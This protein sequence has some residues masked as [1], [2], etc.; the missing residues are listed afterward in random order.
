MKYHALVG[1]L[2]KFA[3]ETDDGSYLYYVSRR[4]WQRLPSLTKQEILD[5]VLGFL[6]NWRSRIPKTPAVATALSIAFRDTAPLFRALAGRRL[7]DIDLAGLVR[8]GQERLSAARAIACILDRLVAVGARFSHV[9]AVKVMHMVN[10][11]LFVMWDN[12]ILV[13][14]GHRREPYGWF[15]AH[16]FLPEMQAEAAEAIR[17]YQDTNRATRKQAIQAIETACAEPKTLAKRLDEY[18][19]IRRL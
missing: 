9:A 16:Q 3:R 4:E 2:K 5:G 6:N 14:R 11:G 8:V 15:Y 19:Y 10:P 1:A 12:T 18:N 13:A 17:D 7:E